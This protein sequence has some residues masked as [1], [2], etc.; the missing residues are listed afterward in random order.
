M[1]GPNCILLKALD[2]H[3]QTLHVVIVDIWYPLK[4]YV[5]SISGVWHKFPAGLSHDIN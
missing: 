1:G 3:G 2:L 5:A 4:H